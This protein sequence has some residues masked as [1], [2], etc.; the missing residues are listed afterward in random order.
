VG[1]DIERRDRLDSSRATSPLMRA[2]NAIEVDTTSLDI[3]QVVNRLVDIARRPDRD[4]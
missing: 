1:A 3:D 4:A 2:E